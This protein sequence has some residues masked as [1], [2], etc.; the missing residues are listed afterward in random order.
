M[1]WL[2]FCV[3]NLIFKVTEAKY[4]RYAVSGL[5]VIFLMD[6]DINSKFGT[7]TLFSKLCESIEFEAAIMDI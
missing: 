5:G 1:N 2:D 4:V 3:C 6:D 7:G